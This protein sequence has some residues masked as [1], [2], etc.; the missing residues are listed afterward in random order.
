M[1]EKKR[2]RCPKAFYETGFWLLASRFDSA[3]PLGR[4]SFDPELITEGLEAERLVA[5]WPAASD[6]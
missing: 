6:Q 5:G 1:E 4:E 3:E 2:E